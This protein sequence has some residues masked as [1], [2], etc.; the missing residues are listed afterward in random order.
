M[1]RALLLI[2][3]SVTK[4][5]LD[6]RYGDQLEST[7]FEEFISDPDLYVIGYYCYYRDQLL[8]DLRRRK[9][10]SHSLNHRVNAE[11]YAMILGEMANVRYAA[12]SRSDRLPIDISLQVRERDGSIHLRLATIGWW[13][14]PERRRHAFREHHSRTGVHQ[15]QGIAGF[16]LE[17]SLL[18]RTDSFLG[19]PIGSI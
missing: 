10:I 13:P 1:C 12:Q 11:L 3:K 4:D 7:F 2:M 19:L 9:L 18:I 17:N 16:L 15:V 8:I 14:S 6:V 5:G